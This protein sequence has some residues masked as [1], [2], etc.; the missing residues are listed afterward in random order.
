MRSF[1]RKGLGGSLLLAAIWTLGCGAAPMS[2][3][4]FNDLVAGCTRD[5]AQLAAEIRQ[6][7]NGLNY[8]AQL[9]K[10]QLDQ[11]DGAYGKIDSVLISARRK[12][13]GA[14][15]PYSNTA[16]DLR[17]KCLAFLAVEESRTKGRVGEILTIAKNAQ[18]PPKTRW[19]QIEALIA[20]I[21][22]D[23]KPAYEALV[24][25][26]QKYADENHYKLVQKYKDS[27]AK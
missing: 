12:L 8:D 26:Q 3:A 23:E 13:E 14:S 24:A 20:Q 2:R 22:A 4:G 9:T 1:L 16:G 6:P 15:L 7:L 25:A 19:T 27:D 10:E 11:L 18:V 17:D 5:L 21:E